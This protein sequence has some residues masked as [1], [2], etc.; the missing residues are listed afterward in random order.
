MGTHEESQ[1]N[2]GNIASGSPSTFNNYYYSENLVITHNFVCYIKKRFAE[3]SY[4]KQT[5]K[6]TKTI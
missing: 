6:E 3:I 1:I 2:K 5:R 4:L